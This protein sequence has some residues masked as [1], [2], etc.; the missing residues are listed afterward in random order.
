MML[1]PLFYKEFDAPMVAGRPSR[2]K[3][4]AP[5]GGKEEV[6]LPPPP[7]TFN[8][9]ELKSAERDAYS[10]GFLDGTKEGHLQAQNE[11]ADVERELV[12]TLEQF[13]KGLTPILA[14]YTNTVQQLRKDMPSLALSIAK[15]VA[16]DA[17][18]Q[19]AIK[20]VEQ[21]AMQGVEAMIAEPKIQVTVHERLADGLRGKLEKLAARLQSAS[22]ITVQPDADIPLA[23]YRIEWKHGGMERNTERL[24]DKIDHII[25]A[26]IRVE[27]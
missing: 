11:H 16:G 27:Q 1:E 4:F 15:K 3:P 22:H 12:A 18:S 25:A 10:R 20:V 17:L 13:A 6:P 7:P 19:D 9:E 26:A 8:E 2:K 21:A 24:W 14:D 23:D 5:S